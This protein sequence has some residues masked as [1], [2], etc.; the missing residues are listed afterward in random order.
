MYPP[1][2]H[3]VLLSFVLLPQKTPSKYK[4]RGYQVFAAPSFLPSFRSVRAASIGGYRYESPLHPALD[5][6]GSAKP[7]GRYLVHFT[8]LVQYPQLSITL[9]N[10]GIFVEEKIMYCTA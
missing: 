4:G 5:R 10:T 1:I 3:K 2:K 6:E 7:W 8:V 9:I